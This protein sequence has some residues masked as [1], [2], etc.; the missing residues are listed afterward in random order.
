MDGGYLLGFGPRTADVIHDLA[1]SL[2]GGQS[3]D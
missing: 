2:Y 3:A 1:A